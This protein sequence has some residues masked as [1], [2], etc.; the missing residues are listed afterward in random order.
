MNHTA[1][2]AY[3]C[4]FDSGTQEWALHKYIWNDIRVDICKDTLKSVFKC[5]RTCVATY[6]DGTPEP[7]FCVGDRGAKDT[8]QVCMV[9]P[10]SSDA[11]S[12][13]KESVG[14]FASAPTRNLFK[15]CRTSS[16]SSLVFVHIPKTGGE[17]V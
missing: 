7:P 1:S 14:Y 15:K 2:Q 13:N 10:Q 5:P 17:S 16:R 12:E 4:N 9:V 6:N 8:L 11:G 3:Y